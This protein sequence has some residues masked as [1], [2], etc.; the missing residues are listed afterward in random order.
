MNDRDR[1]IIFIA[2]SLVSFLATYTASAI[3]VALP[4]IG[5]ELGLGHTGLQYILTA[6]LMLNAA[7]LV[8]FGRL[9]DVYG[10]RT[11]ILCGMVI[12]LVAHVISACATA[13]WVLIVCRAAGGASA[14][15]FFGN[16]VAILSEIFPQSKRGKILGGYVSIVYLGITVGPFIGGLLTSWLGWRSVFMSV[17]PLC[18]VVMILSY[19]KLPRGISR[20]AAGFYNVRLSVLYVAVLVLLI[21]GCSALP[22]AAGILA[23]IGGMALGSVFIARDNAAER[24]FINLKLFR[25]N[26][27]FLFSNLANLLQ[28]TSTNAVSFLLS[29]FLQNSLIKNLSP[30]SAGFILLTQPLLQAV[31]SPLSGAFSDRVQPKLI[32]AAGV[33]LSAAALLSFAL[34]TPATSITVIVLTLCCLGIGFALF[35]SPNNNAA[36]SAVSPGVF[37]IAS[38]ILA[39]GRILGMSMSLALTAV[40]FNIF[41]R[42]GQPTAA[43]LKSFHTIFI[44]FFVLSLAGIASSLVYP[45]RMVSSDASDQPLD[46]A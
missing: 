36:M 22:R 16:T 33:A 9:A 41:E 46:V 42:S 37:G 21:Y 10:R 6:Y 17:V 32:A 34:T 29:L 19:Y 14:A 20:H 35:T 8:P 44:I 25:S 11:I 45:G 23:V 2:L 3:N 39:T 43:F 7:M 28:Y 1:N 18:L 40:V 24:P 5:A 38:G 12:F 27:T 15:M 31:I 13:G 26:R 30:H 4:A